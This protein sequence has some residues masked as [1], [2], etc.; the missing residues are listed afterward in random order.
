MDQP[1]AP[2]AP[3]P[4]GFLEYLAF[5]S[6]NGS[7]VLPFQPPP[8]SVAPTPTVESVAL[9]PTP[10]QGRSFSRANRGT[11]GVLAEKEKVSKQITASATK[12]KSL[13]DPH[14]EVEVS[15][16]SRVAKT[17]NPKQAKRPRVSKVCQYM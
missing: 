10:T 5:L 12:R 2:L 8:L 11:G 17:L 3:P 16:V 1:A 14:V 6:Q 4:E 15:S 13:V 9:P 7:L